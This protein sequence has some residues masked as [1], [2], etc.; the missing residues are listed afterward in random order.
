MAGFGMTRGNT[1]DSWV[2]GMIDRVDDGK[3]NKVAPRIYEMESGDLWEVAWSGE[4]RNV[5][6]NP[7][8]PMFVGFANEKGS[9]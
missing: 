5:Y 2:V 1:R 9:R 4:D 7:H 3:G 8:I 6:L